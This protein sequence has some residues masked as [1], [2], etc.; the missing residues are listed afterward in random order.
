[1]TIIRPI[2]TNN[3]ADASTLWVGMPFLLVATLIVACSDGCTEANWDGTVIDSAGVT[4]VSNT[5]RGMWRGG[6]AWIVEQD[7]VIGQAEGDAGYLFGQITGIGV[8]SD[9]RI[10]VL[11]QQ[12]SEL[13]VFNSDGVFQ[14]A[15]GNPGNGPGELSEAVGPILMLP[16]DTLLVPDLL[17]LRINR[18]TI[19]GRNQGSFRRDVGE[20]LA[21]RWDV[22]DA[23]TA[24]AQLHA[25]PT[26]GQ[27]PDSLDILV[28]IGSD[29]FTLDTLFRIPSGKTA[30]VTFDEELNTVF[31][32]FAP[33]PVWA[34]GSDGHVIL[35]VNDEYSIGVYD[36][37]GRLELVV[38]LAYE[39][40]PLEESDR[41]LLREKI[42]EFLAFQIP[43]FQFEQIVTGMK[44]AEF[45]PAYRRLWIGPNA[46][47]WVQHV[48]TP[49][50]KIEEAKEVFD[51]GAQHPNVFVGNPRIAVGAPDWDVFDAE[52]R[53]LGV[54]TLP[55]RFEPVEFKGNFIY[56]VLRD[57]LDVE[58]VMRLR[59]VAR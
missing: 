52:G 31:T 46:S 17:N 6:E 42:G 33:E 14:H 54:V 38:G 37:E 53:F 11:D 16:G 51:F 50:D 27:P 19:D 23:G 32:V 13:S 35:G 4:I 3:G 30:S 44:F 26:P 5:T 40:R 20:G 8:A 36:R 41:H 45:Y 47:I 55:S 58:Y 56:G 24:V 25:L 28:S 12:S 39:Q 9:G 18:Y 22:S 34:L 29:G 59:I 49:A 7:L 48:L 43:R 1:M 21:I 15:F 2:R 10:V 57:D